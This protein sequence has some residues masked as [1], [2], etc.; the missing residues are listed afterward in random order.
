MGYGV[1]INTKG[2]KSHGIFYY[3]NF[4]PYVK[5]NVGEIPLGI[6]TYVVKLE[7]RWILIRPSSD[8]LQL[9]E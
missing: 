5:V 6:T 4:T 8:S 9:K 7:K 1:Y 3:I 2:V